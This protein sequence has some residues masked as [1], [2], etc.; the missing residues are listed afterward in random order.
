VDTE[1]KNKPTGGGGQNPFGD[2]FISGALCELISK[3]FQG[4]SEEYFPRLF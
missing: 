4:R 2:F 1:S 3:M